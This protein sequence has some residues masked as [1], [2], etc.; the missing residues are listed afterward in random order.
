MDLFEKINWRHRLAK[1]IEQAFIK[2]TVTI[3]VFDQDNIIAFGRVVGDG[4]YYAMLNVVVDPEYQG[5]GVGKY[6]VNTL[7][8]QL[9]NYHFVNL[10]AAPGG[11]NFHENLGMEKANHCFYPA[12]GPKTVPTTL[13]AR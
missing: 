7:N 4:R 8:G 3:F 9:E 1:E 6:L 5:K 10:S 11:D 12:S 13:P 2:S